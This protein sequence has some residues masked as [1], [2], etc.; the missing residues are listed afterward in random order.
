MSK[1]IIK[2]SSI[3]GEECNTR[4]FS[5]IQE[6]LMKFIPSL[7]FEMAFKQGNFALCES[8]EFNDA[9]FGNNQDADKLKVFLDNTL[10]FR[11]ENFHITYLK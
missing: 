3:K 2:E 10:N 8:T 11:Y 5:L 9:S 4:S 7:K 1:F 6:D